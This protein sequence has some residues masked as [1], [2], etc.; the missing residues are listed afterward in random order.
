[1]GIFSSVRKIFSATSGVFADGSQ[2][3]SNEIG[4]LLKEQ[5]FCAD[6]RLFTACEKNSRQYFIEYQEAVESIAEY[7][8]EYALFKEKAR[9]FTTK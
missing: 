7:E 1:M 5:E 9:N 6:D 3:L 4:H 8:E 2:Y